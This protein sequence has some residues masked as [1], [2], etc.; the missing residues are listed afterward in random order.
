[1]LPS[2]ALRPA[3]DKVAGLWV[4]RGFS[5]RPAHREAERVE[6]RLGVTSS[7]THILVDPST[8]EGLSNTG[9]SV[10]T[11]LAS[12][13]PACE[14]LKKISGAGATLKAALRSA[15]GGS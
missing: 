10:A 5:K 6:I 7:S 9:S 8:L 1:M 3:H 11:F 14:R 12:A 15:P 4:Y 13:E 2:S